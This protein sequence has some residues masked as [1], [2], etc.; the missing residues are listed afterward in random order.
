[1]MFFRSRDILSVISASPTNLSWRSAKGSCAAMVLI[2]ELKLIPCFTPSAPHRMYV[3]TS[4]R[5]MT[6]LLFSTRPYAYCAK[7]H[8]RDGFVCEAVRSCNEKICGVRPTVDRSVAS[9]LTLVMPDDLLYMLGELRYISVKELHSPVEPPPFLVESH[10]FSGWPCWMLDR[11]WAREKMNHGAPMYIPQQ[12]E[13]P[14]GHTDN[15]TAS[16]TP[17]ETPPRAQDVFVN[18]SNRKEGAQGGG[19]RDRERRGVSL[20]DCFFVALLGER[21]ERF[22]VRCSSKALSSYIHT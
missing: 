14:P 8:Q 21:E 3:R 10:P 2:L 9:K 6:H 11:L 15:H 20:Q 4:A 12:N 22:I 17:R 19:D 18:V 7:E 5:K 13:E 1:M 16:S